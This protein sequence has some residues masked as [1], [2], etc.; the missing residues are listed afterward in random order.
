MNKDL[1]DLI[2]VAEGSVKAETKKFNKAEAEIRKFINDLNIKE[3]ETLVP[4]MLI[5]DYYAQWA[6]PNT[7]S[8][9]LFCKNFNRYFTSKVTYGI[10]CYKV[11]PTCFGLPEFYSVYKDNRF[12]YYK[13]DNIKNSSLKGVYSIAGYYV[14]RLRTE[15]GLHYL[16]RFKSNR[17]AAYRHDIEAF[18]HFGIDADLNYPEKMKEYEKKIKEEATP[19]RKTEVS[20]SKPKIPSP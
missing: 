9:Y 6:K 19:V 17:E 12:N 7:L 3:S 16:G 1:E 20:R 8:N 10:K 5:F 13:K 15:E 4:K 14:A 18:K 11:D 2:K